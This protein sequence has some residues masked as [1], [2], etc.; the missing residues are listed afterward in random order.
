MN[1]TFIKRVYALSGDFV[2][3]VL[4]PEATGVALPDL[5]RSGDAMLLF[6]CVQKTIEEDNTSSIDVELLFARIC[7]HILQYMPRARQEEGFGMVVDMERCFE[8]KY[9][10]CDGGKHVRDFA[11]IFSEVCSNT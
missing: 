11:V 10:F 7:L 3:K 5:I 2:Y 1:T 8:A 9:K 4:G 6:S